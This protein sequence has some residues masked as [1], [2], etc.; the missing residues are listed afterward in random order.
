MARLVIKNIGPLKEVDVELK[1]VNVFIGRQSSGK[2]TLAKIVSFC[3]WLDKSNQKTEDVIAKGAFHLL[4]TYS[5]LTEAYFSDESRIFYEG[6]NIAYAYNWPDNE[7][8]L[9][10]DATKFQEAE[11]VHVK[12]T[13]FR[14]VG[15]NSN[16][17]VIYIPAERNFVSAVHNLRNYAEDND[18]LQDFV[19]TWYQV[20][21]KFSKEQAFDILNLGA[22]YYY[23]EKDYSDNVVVEGGAQLPLEAASS[24]L[25]SVIPLMTIFDWF[26]SGIYEEVRPFSPAEYE[27]IMG[28]IEGLTS[29]QPDEKMKRMVDRLTGFISGKIYSHTQFIVE[30]PEQNLFPMTQR[31]LL[32]YMISAINHGKNHRL[33]MTTHSP[34]VL[35]Q[36]NLLFKAFDVNQQ[37]DGASLNYDDTNVY[38]IVD[39]KL[40]NLKLKNAHL[41]DPDYLSQFIADIYDQYESLKME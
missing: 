27:E 7:S 40:K 37:I 41:V 22:K 39:G 15:R 23:S 25:Q 17:K 36:L 30:E 18:N 38:A 28:A 3:T 21:R 2:S 8:L 16:P 31:E 9:F 12:E 11:C 20:K 26:S 5:R 29:H 14:S 33:L 34:Y 6:D 35:N 24:G 32:N 19:N 4:S 10:Q 1:K 13:F